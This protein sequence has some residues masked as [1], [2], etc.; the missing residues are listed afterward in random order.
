MKKNLYTVGL[1]SVMG[2]IAGCASSPS[3]EQI[4]KDESR[5]AAVRASEEDDRRAHEQKRMEAEISQ[6]PEWALKQVK[7]DS[8]GV[9]AVGLG[10]SDNMRIALHKATLEAEFGLAKNFSQELSGSERIYTQ[11][12][13]GTVGHEQYTALIDKLVSQVPVIGF[14]II[15]QEVKAINGKYNAFVLV[16]L[17]YQQFNRVLQDQRAKTEDKTIAKAFDDL[18]RRLNQRRQQRLDEEK[19]QN[20][21]TDTKLPVAPVAD[22]PVSSPVP[23]KVSSVTI[24]TDSE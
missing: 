1:L 17:P 18:E 19:Q 16:K 20:N 10:E 15:N 11:D 9:F 2:I 14:E 4:A 5:A 23:S 21:G 6:V 7:P 22:A 8:T 12:N 24:K 3:R 13:N